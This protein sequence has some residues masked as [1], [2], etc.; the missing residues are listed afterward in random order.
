VKGITAIRLEALPDP[1]FAA[2][3]PGA[4]NN[5]NFVL[6]EFTVTANGQPV[7]FNRV[8]A[9]FSQQGW[10]VGG[11][12]DGKKETGWAVMPEFGKPH[13][14][15]FETAAPLAADA[16]VELE[17]GVTLTFVLDH[18]QIY[19]QHNLG[20]FRLSATNA[21]NPAGGQALPVNVQ[22]ILALAPDQ[23][24]DQQKNELAAYY[25]TV[26]PALQ[27][28]RDELAAAEKQKADFTATMPTCLV[29]VAGQPREIRIK[30]RGNW[31]DDS[32]PVVTPAIPEVMGKLD[33]A[34]RPPSRMDLANWL[35]SRENP[36]TAR[37]FV[38]RLW[39]LYFGQGISKVLDDLGAQGEW[40]THPE[41]L[42]WLAVDFMDGGWD[43][44]RAVKTIVTS[45]TYRLASKP[46]PE[47][48]EKDPYNR[49]YARQ[50]RFR[51]EA[52]MVRDNALY[53]SGLLVERLGG[54]SVFPYQPA[55]YWYALNFPTREWQ[56]DTGDNL[57]RRGL[58][59]HWQRSFLHP[60]LLAFDAPSREE[61]T[62]ERARSNIPQQAL[63]LLN[64]P[65]YVEAA[66]TFAEKVIKSGG[67]TPEARL[68]FAFRTAVSREPTAEELKV[69]TG[70]L[71]K[72]GKEYVADEDSA[73][74]LV[75][76][77]ARPVPQDIDAGE[78]AAWTSVSR[79]ILNLHETITRE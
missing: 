16:N 36:L 17:G 37:V 51:L 57:Y 72:H 46:T 15:I 55:G 78:L 69:L 50:G 8:T 65:T 25:R 32:G 59:T 1:A 75:S 52:E 56:N 24:N 29:T 73:T 26:A 64:D 58:Y 31:L 35:V 74:K 5:G 77:G 47:Q 14:A 61:A 41:L 18:Q 21:S 44:K 67:A 3:G 66:R 68:K 27:P 40:P 12:I 30:P 10:G 76:T 28:V 6:T 70:L 79:V 54:K 71:D 63:V 19:A 2:G 11:T 4:S 45:G 49:L 9:A 23:R 7:K 13:T 62:C 38:N 42:D 22:G 60:S 20:K 33:V 53:V 34:G 43:V 48:K 39:K